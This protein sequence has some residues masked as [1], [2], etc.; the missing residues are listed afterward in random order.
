VI[1]NNLEP[2]DPPSAD[3]AGSS[4]ASSS[5]ASSS[6]A[7]SPAAA[8]G[9]P[10]NRSPQ[11][12]ALDP[13]APAL[14]Q[15]GVEPQRGRPPIRLSPVQIVAI[16]AFAVFTVFLTWRTKSLEKALLNR[17]PAADI[18]SKTAPGFSLPALD[19]R[20]ISLSDYAGKKVVVSY[21]ASWCGPCKVE[22]PQLRDF[23]KLYHKAG[24]NF[25][26]LAISIDENRSDAEAYATAEKLPF[27]VLLDTNSKVADSY[28]V[29]GI[30]TM[31]VIDKSGKVAY[32]HTGLDEG[33]QFQLMSQLGIKFPDTD[34]GTVKHD[35]VGKDDG[36][37]SDDRASH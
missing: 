19:G 27:P 1:R 9:L 34:L 13:T 12:T 6:A 4:L 8:S 21:W 36:E 29:E 28:S 2:L 25:E 15:L 23:Y 16:A 31:V 22:M 35:K 17:N 33:M 7:P 14:P 20:T 32:A 3:R 18:V 5:A 11:D 30:P 24:S 26:I 10:E 37:S